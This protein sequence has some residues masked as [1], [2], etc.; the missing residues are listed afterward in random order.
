MRHHLLGVT[1]RSR[2]HNDVPNNQICLYVRELIPVKN[3][4][5]I[6]GLQYLHETQGKGRKIDLAETVQPKFKG[7]KVKMHQLSMRFLIY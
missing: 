6:K 1:V 2:K 4:T 3:K 5:K 7:L